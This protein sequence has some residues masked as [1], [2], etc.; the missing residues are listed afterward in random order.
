MM[1]QRRLGHNSRGKSVFVADGPSPHVFSRGTGSVAVTELWG[2]RGCPADNR[3]HRRH[4]MPQA[5][6]GNLKALA[7]EIGIVADDR[8]GPLLDGA[9]ENRVDLMRSHPQRGH[10]CDR[11]GR[12]HVTR[13]HHCLGSARQG[14]SR[15]HVAL[16]V[17]S[18]GGDRA[19]GSVYVRSTSPIASKFYAPQRK[20]P[21]AKS[22]HMLKFQK[23]V[24][25]RACLTHSVAISPGL[26][27]IE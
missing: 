15:H 22:G 20:T 26:K 16:W 18:L 8:G 19:R 14:A 3:G 4:S 21:S 11:Q 13:A 12:I 25:E 7:F 9:D 27:Q 6:R 5:Q 2:T 10:G 23:D 24:T 1:F 17:I